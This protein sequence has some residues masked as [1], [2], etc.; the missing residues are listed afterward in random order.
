MM[1]SSYEVDITIRR[2]A[3]VSYDAASPGPPTLTALPLYVH[4]IQNEISPASI[5][6]PQKP[7]PAKLG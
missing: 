7:Q 4:C 3:G 1:M 5:I 2:Q 6:H